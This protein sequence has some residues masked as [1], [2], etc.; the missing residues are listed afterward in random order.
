VCSNGKN[1]HRFE[2]FELLLGAGGILRFVQSV[3]AGARHGTLIAEPRQTTNSGILGNA[4]FLAAL[5][6]LQA[7]GRRT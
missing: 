7:A 3:A 4:L 2:S 6:L 5:K 1:W